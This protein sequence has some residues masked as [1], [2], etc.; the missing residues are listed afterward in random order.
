[1][2]GHDSAGLALRDHVLTEMQAAS[3][4]LTAPRLDFFN[5]GLG[6]CGEY[7]LRL[8]GRKVALKKL[9]TA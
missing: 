6:S 1:M 4:D 9:S 3:A 5:I 2:I 7:N 8:A